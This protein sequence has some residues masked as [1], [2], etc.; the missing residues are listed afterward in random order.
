MNTTTD[1]K[2]A[3]EGAPRQGF[4]RV[5]TADNVELIAEWRARDKKHAKTWWQHVSVG[6]TQDKVPTPLEGVCFF[7]NVSKSAVTEHLKR[8][9]TAEEQIERAFQGYA[10]GQKLY[11]PFVREIPE[12]RR[13]HIGDKVK[14]GAL[15]D[16][17]VADLRNDRQVVV[18]SY[19]NINSNYGRPIDNGTAHLALH[20]LEVLKRHE[21][22]PASMVV[23]S[24]LYDS[25]RTSSL[26][27]LMNKVMRG[28]ND[29]PDYQRGYSWTDA[30]KQRYLESVITGR[31][32]GRFIFVVRQYPQPDETLDGKQRLSCLMDFMAGALAYNG[33]FW[34]ELSERD[35]NLVE[36]RSVQFA[37]V[38][39]KRF[40]RAHLLK[41]FLE[42]NC[43]GVP[44]SEEHLEHVKG[45][46][47]DE[48]KKHPQK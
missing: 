37:E 32:I 48:L 36:N 45:L 35:R 4:Y 25:F 14:V 21:V 22:E 13:L 26:D 30:D 29:S 47:A 46:L 12:A 16:A 41:M 24:V 5:K 11:H 43:A 23:D 15:K 1:W 42:V 19:R 10:Q 18:I 38:D 28:L 2:P 33:V 31:D 17:V 6:P 27:S 39:G 7:A 34:H 20:W 9:P 8:Q 44:Q 40:G 3:T